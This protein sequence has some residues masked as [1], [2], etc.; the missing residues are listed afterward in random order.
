MMFLLYFAMKITCFATAA[1]HHTFFLP[2]AVDNGESLGRQ[3]YTAKSNPLDM[4]C[5]ERENMPECLDWLCNSGQRTRPKWVLNTSQVRLVP[6][7]SRQQASRNGVISVTQPM[8]VLL[9]TI[10]TATGFQLSWTTPGT[11]TGAFRYQRTTLRRRQRKFHDSWFYFV[12]LL[13]DYT[14]FSWVLHVDPAGQPPS[15]P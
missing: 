8:F 12:R 7:Q 11:E 3:R 9:L 13:D 15:M 5:D 6:Q 4:W 14:V 2:H 10:A 1:H